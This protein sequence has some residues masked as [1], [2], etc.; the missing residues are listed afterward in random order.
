MA[1]AN[2]ISPWSQWISR[3]AVPRGGAT[4]LLTSATRIKTTS[5][6]ALLLAGRSDRTG[7]AGIFAF[8]WDDQND[9]SEVRDRRVRGR[10]M[11]RLG[12]KL[13]HMRSPRGR[14][15]CRLSGKLR[16]R[17]TPCEP[18]DRSATSWSAS[19]APGRVGNPPLQEPQSVRNL[20]TPLHQRGE[21]RIASLQKMTKPHGVVWFDCINDAVAAG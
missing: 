12:S 8:S 6:V 17:F 4:S 21:M 20:A 1:P 2:S 10:P 18:F 16:T 7:E 15:Q 3:L 11:M 9:R 14:H 5:T 19:V 13:A